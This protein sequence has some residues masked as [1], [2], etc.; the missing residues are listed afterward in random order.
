MLSRAGGQAKA[1]PGDPV[2]NGLP[3][4]LNTGDMEDGR[5]GPKRRKQQGKPFKCVK[6]FRKPPPPLQELKAHLAELEGQSGVDGR[7]VDLSKVDGLDPASGIY[8]LDAPGPLGA[9]AAIAVEEKY[10]PRPERHS[11]R[12]G[13]AK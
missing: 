3:D 2:V 9:K 5:Q 12:A 6:S 1:H 7:R 8:G 4:Y 10:V 11:T 13:S